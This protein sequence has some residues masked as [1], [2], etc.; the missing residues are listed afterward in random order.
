MK[1]FKQCFQEFFLQV[2]IQELYKYEESLNNLTL[3]FQSEELEQS[4]QNRQMAKVIVQ[5]RILINI[6]FIINSAVVYNSAEIVKYRIIFIG[7]MFICLYLQKISGKYWNITTNILIFINSVISVLLFAFFTKFVNTAQTNKEDVMS[8]SLISGLQQ[9]LFAMSFF[10]IQSNYIMQSLTMISFFLILMGI[11]TKFLNYR[12]WTQYLPLTFTCHLLRQNEKTNRLNPLLIHKSH[13]NLEACK[14]LYDETVPTSIIILEENLYQEG[15][16]KIEQLNS[17]DS[18][19]EKLYTQE[20]KFMNV[21]YFNKSASIHFETAEENILTE[22]L[23]EIE[24]LNSE[25]SILHSQKNK[26]LDKISGLQSAIQT[27]LRF[28]TI[29]SFDYQIMPTNKKMQCQRVVQNQIMQDV[30]SSKV[31]YYDAQAQ[32]CLWDGKQCIMLILNDTTDRVLRIKHLQELDNYKDNLLAAVSHDLKTPLN[33]LNILT[34]LIKSMMENKQLLV[35]NDIQEIVVQIDHMISNQ[36]ILLTMINDLI[37]YSQ[38]KK[39]GLRLNYTQFDLSACI[40][41]IKNMFK[42]Q[43]DLKHLQFNVIGLNEKIIMY[44]D[45][46]RLQQIL[47]NLISNAIKFTSNGQITL[48]INKVDN[49]NQQLIY[50]SVQDTGIGIPALIQSKLFKAYSTFNLGNQNSQGVGLGL[51]I[52]RNLVGLLGPSEF[53]EMSSKENQGSNFSFSIYMDAKQKE[54]N[55]TNTI[56]TDNGIP[57][58]DPAPDHPT[59]FPLIKR[60]KKKYPTAINASTN[61]YQKIKILIVDDITFNIYALRELLKRFVQCDIHVAFNGREALK[62]VEDTRFDIIFMDIEMPELNGFEATKLIRQFEQN[63]QFSRSKICMLSGFQGE[64]DLKKS[65]EIGADLHL[66]KPIEISVLKGIL[67]ELKFI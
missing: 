27:E 18:H 49:V 38:L 48:K 53:I 4:Y 65:L 33:G 60:Q 15:V 21:S 20:S 13:K 28:N 34:H 23:A 12:L 3:Q 5:F 9:G 51:V 7:W 10:L 42:R 29:N 35:R 55:F 2:Q 11:F 31:H 46:V 57:E 24:I 67:E 56:Q 19:K 8:L 14:K 43:M 59:P 58:S 22:R 62:K 61:F 32:G 6:G 47:F 52:S 40:Q 37:D 66:P 64:S 25:D 39:Q 41:Q 63:N 17:V 44:S 54:C 16:N 50:F 1:L 30:K 26:L 45:Q 36:Q